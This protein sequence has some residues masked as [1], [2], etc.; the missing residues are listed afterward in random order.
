MT[1]LPKDLKDYLIENYSFTLPSIVQSSIASDG[2]TK[3]GLE[4]MDKSYVEM[5]VIPAVQKTTLCISSQVGCARACSFCATG[6]HGLKRNLSV[7]E[8]VGQIVLASKLVLPK[9]ITN[10]VFMGMGEPLDNTE[11]VLRALKIIQADESIS[12]SPRRTTI[13]TCGVIPGILSLADSGIKTKLAVSLNSALDDK[14][15]SLMPINK[16][17]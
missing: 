12:F 4:T 5:V 9:R 1:N 16:I 13:S 6:L 10:I 3:H 2:T 7:E 15:S 8:I 17:Y 11:H 14:R